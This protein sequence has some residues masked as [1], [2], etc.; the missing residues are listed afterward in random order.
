MNHRSCETC[1]TFEK[2]YL[3]TGTGYYVPRAYFTIDESGVQSPMYFVDPSLVHRVRRDTQYSGA[4]TGTST[5][6]STGNGNIFFNPRE[7]K[8]SCP[9]ASTTNIFAPFSPRIWRRLRK[10]WRLSSQRSR[11]FHILLHGNL[12]TRRVSRTRLL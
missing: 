3:S 10:L 9:T 2:L 4:S 5:G 1:T 7:C 12:F 8:N 6:T 11:N